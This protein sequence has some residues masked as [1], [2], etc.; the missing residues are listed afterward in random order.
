VDAAGLN[1][2]LGTTVRM[3]RMRNRLVS[4]SSF[5]LWILLAGAPAAIAQVST[6]PS[7]SPSP[8]ADLPANLQDQIVLAGRVV[9]DRGQTSG[10]I[11]VFTGRVQVAGVVQGDV[12]VVDGPVLISGQVSGS[13]ISFDGPVRLTGTAQVSGD[14]IARENVEMALGSQV[15]GQVR[16]HAP[17]T[18]KT[19]ARVLGRFASW[20]AVSVSTLLLGLLLLWVVPRG[21][22]RVLRAA[23]ETPWTSAMWGLVMSIVLPAA[24]ALFV[25]SLVALPLGLVLLLALAM[26]LFV[27]Y[28]WSLWVLGRAIVSEH[29]R[30]LAFLAGWAI[31]RAVGLIPVVSGVTFGLAAMFGLGAMTVATWR[32]RGVTRRGGGSHRRGH[33]AL[34]EASDEEPVGEPIA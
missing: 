8:G 14:V 30:L 4:V 15:G 23:R 5:V 7:P 12:V 22:E 24:G 17:F 13:V 16:A 1:G 27:A 9:V 19:P 29:G 34:P 10:E 26:L 3:A 28:T 20:L 11:V 2:T 33:V 18:F 31:A 32:A 21:A 6:T 25:L